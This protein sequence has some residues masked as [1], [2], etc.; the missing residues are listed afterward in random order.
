MICR[1]I[2]LPTQETEEMERSNRE[3]EGEEIAKRPRFSVL[4]VS[5]YQSDAKMS[6]SEEKFRYSVND[7]SSHIEKFLQSPHS[8]CTAL[9]IFIIIRYQ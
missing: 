7:N 1:T 3:N 8:K 4:P 9:Y 5:L 6:E 2:V